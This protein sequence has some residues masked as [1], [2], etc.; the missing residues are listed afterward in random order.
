MMPLTEEQQAIKE[1]LFE[2]KELMDLMGYKSVDQMTGYLISGDPTYIS[3]HK[4]ARGKISS[5]ERD[6][7]IEVLLL[8]LFN[9]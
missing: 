6:E 2:V 8:E 1:M 5:V 9:K 4:D 3:T 7:I